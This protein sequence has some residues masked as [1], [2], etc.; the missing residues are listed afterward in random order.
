MKGSFKQPSNINKTNS[1]LK[2]LNMKIKPWHITLKVQ[3]MA[4][5][6]LTIYLF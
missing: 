2:L 6:R 4:L 1:H 5:D 3:I